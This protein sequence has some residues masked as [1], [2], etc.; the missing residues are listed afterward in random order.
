MFVVL[1]C[2]LWIGILFRCPKFRL[3]SRYVMGTAVALVLWHIPG[4]ITLV[5]TPETVLCQNEITRATE[6]NR[7]CAAQGSSPPP[8][9]SFPKFSR[10]FPSGADS[11]ISFCVLYS[12][13]GIF[14]PF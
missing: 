6:S 11:R 14:P 9:P 8:T 12:C 2:V 4:F 13:C 10:D 3:R 7:L 5:V 1:Y